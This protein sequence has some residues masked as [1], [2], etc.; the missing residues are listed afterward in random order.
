[1]HGLEWW[2]LV[3]RYTQC[4][5]CVSESSGKF[6]VFT[7]IFS[8]GSVAILRRVQYIA[9]VLPSLNIKIRIDN[10]EKNFHMKRR[11]SG[12][13]RTNITNTL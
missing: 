1:M 5:L 10:R 2:D 6:G 4:A 9:A 11:G 13:G 12:R 8:C 7:R 3:T